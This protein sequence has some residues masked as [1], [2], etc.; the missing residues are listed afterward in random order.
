M[1]DDDVVASRLRAGRATSY[2]DT[3]IRATLASY[4]QLLGPLVGCGIIGLPPPQKR[5][6]HSLLR[7]T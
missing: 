5:P 2:T 7:G 4:L 3:V 6:H 1:A